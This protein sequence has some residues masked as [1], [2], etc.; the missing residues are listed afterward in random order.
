MAT[1]RYTYTV[2]MHEKEPQEP[3]EHTS[4]H[5]ISWGHALRPPSHN[6]Y[7]RVPPFVSFSGPTNPLGSPN[8]RCTHIPPCT[9]TPP[10]EGWEDYKHRQVENAKV[11]KLKCGNRRYGSEK[12]ATCQCL[13]PFWLMIVPYCQRVKEWLPPSDVR[14]GYWDVPPTSTTIYTVV[15]CDMLSE[16]LSVSSETDTVKYTSRVVL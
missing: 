5:S 10:Q 6:P 12:K 16:V 8:G 3:P 2:Y 4:E 7:C 13:V 1:C 9:C 11:Q 15:Q 14:T